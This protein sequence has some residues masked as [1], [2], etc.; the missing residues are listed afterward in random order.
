MQRRGH[1]TFPPE[2]AKYIKAL[3]RYLRSRTYTGPIPELGRHVPEWERNSN[4]PAGLENGC[5]IHFY[6]KNPALV[7]RFPELKDTYGWTIH[8]EAA[9]K[10]CQ[11]IT[12]HADAQVC[13]LAFP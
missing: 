5:T 9:V 3:I 6:A 12:H 7:L 8:G 4:T 13:T 11:I 2:K 10:A 1:I